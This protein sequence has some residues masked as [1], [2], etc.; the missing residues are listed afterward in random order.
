[1]KIEVKNVTKSYAGRTVLDNVSYLITEP[2]ITKI[3][4]ASGSGKTTLLRIISGLEKPDSGTVSVEGKLIYMFQEHRLVKGISLLENVTLGKKEL[5]PEATEILTSLGLG[6]DLEKKPDEASGGMKQ[7]TAFAR[8]LIA[9]KTA[10]VLLIDEPVS[11]QD[12]ANAEI[13]MNMIRKLS[14]KKIVLLVSH[15]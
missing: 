14:E 8:M 1:M 11:A 12:P 4:G 15:G 9:A 13:I 3:D 7:R 2:G 6:N 10:D 5:I